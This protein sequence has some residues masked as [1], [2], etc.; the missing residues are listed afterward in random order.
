MLTVFCRSILKK[1]HKKDEKVVLEL[2]VQTSRHKFLAR[3]KQVMWNSKELKTTTISQDLMVYWL[4]PFVVVTHSDQY[5][6]FNVQ[7]LAPYF[8]RY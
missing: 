4:R 5:F 1:N 3:N 8:Y 6:F 7:F 2:Q